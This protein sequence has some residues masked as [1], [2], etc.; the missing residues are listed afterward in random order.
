MLYIR[1]SLMVP[2]AGHAE[3]AADLL[4]AVANYLD[5]QAGYLGAYVLQPARNSGMIGR[6]TLW[7]D[8]ASADAVA[9]SDHMLF[10][11][12]ELAPL[13]AQRSHLEFGFTAERAPVREA[14]LRLRSA[15]ALAAIEELLR[16][17]GAER[18][19]GAS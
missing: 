9:Q 3:A 18:G 7:E 8:E 6:V 12:S 1:I 4:D 11:R 15:D 5:G 10:L 13:I 2:R 14:S 17:P 19:Q 16:E